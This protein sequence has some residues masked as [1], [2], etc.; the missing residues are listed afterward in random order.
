MTGNYANLSIYLIALRVGAIL[1]ALLFVLKAS[2]ASLIG[3]D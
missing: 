3:T 1:A 2:H